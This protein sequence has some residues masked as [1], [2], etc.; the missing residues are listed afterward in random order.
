MTTE[1]NKI[2]IPLSII[3]TG[4]II[5]GAIIFSNREKDPVGNN[6][7]TRETPS[8]DTLAGEISIE[9]EP[10]LGDAS[11]PIMLVEF[12]DFECPFCGRFAN[13]TFLQIKKEYVDTGKVK[14]VFK[15]FPLPFHKD[16]QLAAEAGECAALQGKFWEYKEVLFKNQ[17]ALSSN[18]CKKYAVDLGLDSGKFNHCLDS[19]ETKTEV[20]QDLKEGKIADVSG[21]PS[22]L[23]NGELLVGAQPFSAFKEKIDKLLKTN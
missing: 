3:I 5:G 6:Q 2:L 15:N 11:A 20:E 19:R 4:V 22:F 16:A 17:G 8:R 12:S 23:I 7:P 14:V 21:T 10:V 9:G 13:N 1:N 18:D